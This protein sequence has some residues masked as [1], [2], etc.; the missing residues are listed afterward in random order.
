MDWFVL[1]ITINN[2]NFIIY[3]NKKLINYDINDKNNIEKNIKDLILKIRKI[4]KIKI[5]L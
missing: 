4:Y 3:I 5:Y 2:E 1:K